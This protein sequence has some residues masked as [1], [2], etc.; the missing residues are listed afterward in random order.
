MYEIMVNV[1]FANRVPNILSMIRE[2][3]EK[4]AELKRFKIIK[5]PYKIN[6]TENYDRIID[7]VKNVFISV[8]KNLGLYDYIKRINVELINNDGIPEVRITMEW[9]KD[10][11]SDTLLK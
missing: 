1:E 2:N 5:I 9:K 6:F 10:K 7:N 11:P 8:V 4:V 3:Y